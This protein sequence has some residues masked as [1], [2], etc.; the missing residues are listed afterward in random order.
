MWRPRDIA[1]IEMTASRALLSLASKYRARYLRNFYDLNQANLR[2]DAEVPQAF[3]VMAGQP[4]AENV[5]RFLEILT[6]QG[7]EVYE[8]RNELY[9]KHSRTEDFHEIP[10]G[11]FLV[12]LNQPQKNNVLSLF[13]KQV[14]PN[15]VNANGEAE[16]PYDVA[17]WTLPLQMGVE[18]YEVWE[19]R[20]LEKFRGTLKRVDTMN[21]ARAVL[22]L[23]QSATPFP[24]LT[25]PLKTNP[26]IGLYKPFSSSMDEGWT[27]LVFD[28]HNVPYRSISNDDMRAGRL[29]YDSIILAADNENTIMNGLSAQRYPSEFAGGI[30]DAGVENL[31]K[32]VENGG[33]L[34]CFDDSCELVIKRFGLPL[35]NVLSGLTRNQFY[36]PG[37]LV[38]L[39][40]DTRHPY[41]KGMLEDTPAYFITSSAFEVAADAR[42]SVIA[43]YAEKDAL[44]S[45][46]MLGEKYLNAKTALAETNYGK[47]KI[48]LFAFRPQHRGQ[49]F[50]TFPFIFNALEK[51]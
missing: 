43:T 38:K 11:S 33:K 24:K 44:V 16:Q 49:T 19:I 17:G 39:K 3:V 31:K 26:K 51:N 22:N 18:S 35:K 10:L 15:R 13:E 32:F 40:V 27:R 37:S 9:V 12:F 21:Q 8:M 4:R 25:N 30:G 46:W 7:I 1:E 48:V 20:D 45:G 29:D 47:G 6:W 41:A 2:L 5:A 36:N 50:G 42:V 34:I 28:M 14:Y 23:T